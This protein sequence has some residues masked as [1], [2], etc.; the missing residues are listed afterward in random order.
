MGDYFEDTLRLYLRAGDEFRYIWVYIREEWIIVDEGQVGEMRDHQL[1]PI[2]SQTETDGLIRKRRSAGYT[3]I[4]ESQMTYHDIIFEIS[5]SLADEEELDHR[6]LIWDELDAFLAVTG[7]GWTDGASSGLSTM[8][9]GVVV[10]DADVMKA[11]VAN[12]ITGKGLGEIR[13]IIDYGSH[14]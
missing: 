13:G 6:N 11:S 5:G 1:F 2:E 10:V 4:S 3:E 8:E 14:E 7:Q 9:I 12:W